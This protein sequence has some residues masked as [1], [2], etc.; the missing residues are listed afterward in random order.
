MNLILEATFATTLGHS[1]RLGLDT[2]PLGGTYRHLPV[3]DRNFLANGAAKQPQTGGLGTFTP[4]GIYN[5]VNSPAMGEYNSQ[6]TGSY[7]PEGIFW[8]TNG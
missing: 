2:W 4:G 3:T 5:G 8:R 7:P 1:D 6:G